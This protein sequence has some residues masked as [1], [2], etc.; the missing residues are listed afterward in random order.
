MFKDLGLAQDAAKRSGSYT[1]LGTHAREVYADLMDKGFAQK[2]FSS[3][4][5]Y[6]QNKK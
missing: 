4:F 1:P 3:V 6:L 5:Q 2:D